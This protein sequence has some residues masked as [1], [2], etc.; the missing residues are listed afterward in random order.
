M[1]NLTDAQTQFLEST[2]SAAMITTGTDGIPR[3]VRVAVALVDGKL[4]SSGTADR[5][6]T[7]RLRQDPRCTLFVFDNT[8]QALTLETTVRLLEGAEVP[9]QSVQLFRTMQK[10]PSGALNWFGKEMTE[11]EFLQAMRGESRL[12]YEFEINRAY[13]L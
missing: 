11:E 7:K 4:W 12:I 5:V 1:P 6:R 3:A 13:G 2:H 8:W 10:R 9:K